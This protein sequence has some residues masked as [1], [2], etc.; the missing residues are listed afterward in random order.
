MQRR[1]FL[2]KSGLFTLSA[3][4]T[5]STH[6]WIARTATANPAQKRLIV[7]FLRGAVDGLSVVVPYT[8]PVYYQSRPRIAIPKPGQTDGVLKLNNRFGL[9][10]ALAP[11]LPLWEQGSLAFIHACGSPDSSRSHFDAQYYMESGTPGNKS[12]SDGWMNRL[13]ASLSAKSALQAINVGSTTP[14]ILAGRM[15]VAS[16]ATGRN[17]TR[18]LP[19]DRIQV[20]SAFDQLYGGNDPLSRAYREG[21]AT[22]EVLLSE[23]EEEMAIADNGAP[24]PVGFASDAQR[25][26]RLMVKDARVQLAFIPLGGWDTHVNQ[27]ASKG[28]LARNLQSLGQGLSVLNKE[29]GAV[30]KNTAI[31]VISEFGRTV[32]ENGNGGTDHGHGNV[33]WVLGG[34]VRG[35]KVYGQFPGLETSQLHQGRDLAITTDFREV[36][37]PLIATHLK[38]SSSQSSQIFPGFTP[39]KSINLID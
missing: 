26:A 12:T 37:I 27:G 17:A 1:Y 23:L 36:L 15:P 34:N 18:P 13:L 24:P 11:I 14:Q 2:Q 5:A 31:V 8:D 9:H 20:R 7:I 4:A 19:L 21:Q 29:L 25:L 10:P 35:G 3:L 6:A 32:K 38:V 30:Y 39:N 33:L 22:R 16:M 28:N